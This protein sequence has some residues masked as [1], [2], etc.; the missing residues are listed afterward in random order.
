MPE[1]ALEQFL[2]QHVKLVFKDGDQVKAK[3]GVLIS[4]SGDFATIKTEF[5]ICAV[6]ISEVLKV[7]QSSEG[8][9]RHYDR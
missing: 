2:N 5:G 3:Y 7:Q 8:G 6:R 9:A 1:E 4:T